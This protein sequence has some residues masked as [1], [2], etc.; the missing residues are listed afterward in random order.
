MRDKTAELYCYLILRKSA[1]FSQVNVQWVMALAYL[2]VLRYLYQSVLFNENKAEFFLG[3]CLAEINW[4]NFLVNNRIV[5][6]KTRT[7]KIAE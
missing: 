2:F 5:L 1:A 7:C 4:F 3:V 6:L